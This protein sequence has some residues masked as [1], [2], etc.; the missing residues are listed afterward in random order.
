METGK[1]EDILRQA[2]AVV[3]AA[4]LPDDLRA[5]ALEKTVDLMTGISPPSRETGE[6]ATHRGNATT[7][8]L[9]TGDS[10]EKIATKFGIEVDLVDEAFEAEDG[11]PTLIVPRQKLAKSANAA[12]KEIALLVA[13]ARQ[14][15]EVESWTDSKT[16]REAVEGYGKFNSPNFA[17]SIAELEDDFSFS[18]KGQSRR[19]R[20]RRDGFTSAGALTKKLLGRP[21]E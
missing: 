19:V 5:I 2:A 1:I 8:E 4:N 12:T 9:A 11:M 16:I 10:L 13:A 3:D 6:S 18:G 15:A 17:A 20:V 7:P 14:A 21:T